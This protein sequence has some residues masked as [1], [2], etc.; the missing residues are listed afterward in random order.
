MSHRTRLLAA[1]VAVL[2]SAGLAAAQ[3]YVDSTRHFTLEV[4]PGWRALTLKE[5]D[6]A[7]SVMAQRMPEQK[8]QYIA[9]FQLIGSPLLRFPYVLVSAHPGATSGMTFDQME[10]T[11]LKDLHGP[12]LGRVQQ[13]FPEMAGGVTFE[14]PT[15]D[16][17]RRRIVVQSRSVLADGSAIRGLTVIHLGSEGFVVVNC[18]D[19]DLSFERRLPTFDRIN[20]SFRFDD[21]YAFTPFE[22]QP[23]WRRLIGNPAGEMA[24]AGIVCG[25]VGGLCGLI[26]QLFTR[27][28]PQPR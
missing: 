16:R 25:V 18:Y 20:D 7:N 14:S 11:I 1:V 6:L 21:G 23:F 5:I 9:G 4:Q 10:K 19:Q 2:V 26:L 12:D 3:P 8:V 27:K 13:A 22:A 15:L 17:A 24:A 28:K